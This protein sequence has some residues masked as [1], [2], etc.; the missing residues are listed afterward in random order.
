MKKLIRRLRLKPAEY[1]PVFVRGTDVALA[2]KAEAK[3][4][5]ASMIIMGSQGRAGL[6]RL[7]LGSVAERT[8][9]YVRC[10]VLIVKK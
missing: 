4:S 6:G 3:K 1:R 10:P 8:L 5:R 7:M 9:R 2:I